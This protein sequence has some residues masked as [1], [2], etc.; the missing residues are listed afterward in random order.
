M[1]MLNK[2]INFSIVK[3]FKL[4]FIIY[5]F[6]YLFICLFPASPAFAQSVTRQVGVQGGIT[7]TPTPTPGPTSTP[8]PGPA[9]TATPGPTSTPTPTPANGGY[10]YPSVTPTPTPSA[11]GTVGGQVG[12][13]YLSV[14][15]YS[16]PYASIIL[17][18]GNYN[19]RSTVSDEK[20]D[21]SISQVLINQGLSEFCLKATD[22]RN[23]GDSTACIIIK[24]VSS[25]VTVNNIFLP[26]TLGVWKKEITY[27]NSNLAYGYT[28]PGATVNL[29]IV[30]YNNMTTKADANG[31]YRFVLK[32]PGGTYELFAT[33]TYKNINSKSPS[34]S[35]TVK[36][37]AGGN[38]FIAWL[39][40]LINKIATFITTSTVGQL[41]LI[42]PIII[43]IIIF[44]LKLWGSKFKSFFGYIPW[45]VPLVPLTRLFRGKKL[46]HAWMFGY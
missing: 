21:F 39:K 4:R 40:D 16:A 5:L 22:S 13:Y 6:V 25:D 43:L 30:G 34:Q 9:A 44:L 36:V 29:H 32:L 3:L 42:L 15:G 35:V 27:Y 8:T 11:P 37:L 10:I 14:S 26:P 33:A 31:Y 2:Q 18:V 38:L 1:Q 23:L 7:A 28:L 45:L 46:H 41:L 20:G 19:L 17:T 24:P 12:Q